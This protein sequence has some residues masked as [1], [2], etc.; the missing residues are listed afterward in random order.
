MKNK[1][2]IIIALIIGISILGYGAFNYLADIKEL[3]YKQLQEAREY[4]DKQIKRNQLMECISKAEK[5][6]SFNWDND[7]L[8]SKDKDDKCLLPSDRA[9]MHDERLKDNKD[10]CIDIYKEDV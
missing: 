10:R 4:D 3:E 2:I 6:Y 7:P 9:T 8:C 5:Y 1:T